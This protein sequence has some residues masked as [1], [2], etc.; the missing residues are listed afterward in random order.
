VRRTIQLLVL[1]MSA[2]FSALAASSTTSISMSP[3]PSDFGAPVTITATVTATATGTVTFYDGVRILGT[4]TVSGNQAALTTILLGT[5][6]RS[7]TARY[8]GDVNF[9]PSTSVPITQT[10]IAGA[11]IS[12]RSPISIAGGESSHQDVVMGD[13]NGD[14]KADAASISGSGLLINVWLGNGDGTFQTAPSVP[15]PTLNS[16]LIVADINN[17]G[18][19]DLVST[20]SSSNVVALFKGN[21]DGTFQPSVNFAVAG[22][23]GLAVT[24]INLDG[25]ADFL[26]AKQFGGLLAVMIGNGDGTFQ[27]AVDRVFAVSSLHPLVVGDFNGDSKPDLA[28][29]AYPTTQLMVALG[30]GDGSFAAPVGFNIASSPSSI[31]AG[32]VN[33]DGRL[34]LVLNA[35]PFISVLLGNGDGTFQPPSNTNFGT[36]FTLRLVIVDVTGDGKEDALL[37]SY[38]SPATLY[39]LRGNGDGTLQPASETPALDAAPHFAAGD[40]NGDAKV[41]VLAAANGYYPNTPG[42]TLFLGSS[43]IDMATSISPGSG[44]TQGQ[45]GSYS[46]TVA[47]VGELPTSGAVGLTASLPAGFTPTAAS[48]N[49]WV[50]AVATTTCTR[51][52]T[53]APGTA[54]PTITISVNVAP[55]LTG[56]VTA[57]AT[58]SGGGDVNSANN[59]GT[60]TSPVRLITTTVLTAAPNPSTVSQ[61]VALT[62]TVTVGAT[63]TVVFYDGLDI[64]GSAS[65]NGSSAVLNIAT[66]GSGQHSL[67]ARYLGSSTFGTSVSSKVG[68]AVNTVASN[69]FSPPLKSLFTG[70]FYAA[71][72]DLTG[73]GKLDLVLQPSSTSGS[74]QIAILTGNGDG[75]FLPPSFVDTAYEPNGVLIADWNNDGRQDLTLTHYPHGVFHML[76][77]G[78]GTFQSAFRISDYL[79]M[80]VADINA[81]GKLDLVGLSNGNGLFTVLGKGDGTFFPQTIQDIPSLFESLA[82]IGNLNGD[83]FPDIVVGENNSAGKLQ[84]LIGNGDG[85]Y[86]TGAFY[87]PVGNFRSLKISDINLDGKA[88]V[89]ILSDIAASVYL[90]NGNGTFQAAVVTTLSTN[91][92]QYAPLLA[93]FNGDGKPDLAYALSPCIALY[94]G[95]GTGTF[96]GPVPVHCVGWPMPLL[97]ADLNS[98]GRTDLMGWNSNVGQSGVFLGGQFSGLLIKKTHFGGFTIGQSGSTYQITVTS[99]YFAATAGTVTVTDTLPSGFTATAMSG[100]GWACTLATRTCTR[101]DALTTL[102]SYPPIILTVSV[103][104]NLSPSTVSNQASV[105]YNGATNAISDPTALVSASSVQLSIP[106]APM[107][108]GQAATLTATVGGGLTGHVVFF[109]G[110]K[111]IGSALLSAGQAILTTRLVSAGNRLL[112]ATYSGDATHAPSSTGRFPVT[113]KAAPS[114]GFAPPVQYS[115]G[116]YP[117]DLAIADLNSDGKHDLVI[118]RMQ[119]KLS[120]L[121]GAG[122]GTF[123]SMPEL[124]SSGFYSMRPLVADLNRDG[125]PDVI[126]VSQGNVFLDVFLGNGDGTFQPAKK[127]LLLIYLRTA[128]ITDMNSDGLVDVV[129]AGGDFNTYLLRG[130]GDGTFADP[131]TIFTG[132]PVGFNE[133]FPALAI[134]D[135]NSD[136]KLDISVFS[137]ASSL[138]SSFT[139]RAGDGR[140]GFQPLYGLASVT[141]TEAVDVGDLNGDFRPD[142]I[143]TGDFGSAALIQGDEPRFSVIPS[144]ARGSVLADLNGDGKLDMLGQ[145][146]IALGNGDGSFQPFFYFELNAYATGQGIAAGDFNGDGRTDVAFLDSNTNRLLVYLGSQ[147]SIKSSHLGTFA[148]GQIGATYTLTVWNAGP[149]AT[150]GTI[151]VTDTLPTGLTATALS[152][153]GWNC[154]VA[155]TTCTRSDSLPANSAYP[156]LTVTVNV[157]ANA[158]SPV[159]NQVTLSGGGALTVEHSDPTHIGLVQDVAISKTHVGNFYKGQTAAKYSIVV[160]NFG[161]ASTSSSVSVTEELPAGLTASQISGSGWT[162]TQPSGPCTRSDSLAIG[163]SYPALTLT[164]SV[165]LTAPSV[166]VNSAR[167]FSNN[168]LNGA[169]NV[170]NDTTIIVPATVSIG[171]YNAGAWKLDSNG[172]GVFDANSDRSF[173]LGFAGATQFTGDWNGDGRTKAGVYS[174]GY[175]YLDYDGNGVWDNGVIDKLIAWGWAGVTPFVGDWNGNGKTKIGVYSNGFW[176]LDYD[177]N[178]LWD[179]GVTDKQIGWGWAGVTPFVGDWNGNGKTK[180]GVYS[181]GFWFLDYDGN[182]SWDGGVIDKQVGWGWAGVTPIMGDW[183]GDGRMKIGV[184]SGGYWYIDYDGN[185]LWQYPATDKI[186]AMGWAGTTPVIGDWNGDG[187]TKAGAFINGFWYLDHNGNGTFDNATIDRIFGFGAVGDTPVV[188]RW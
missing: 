110:S 19:Q 109:D 133:D 132:T 101:S 66:L 105:T 171:T 112:S 76:G 186:L 74:K 151:T 135:F 183:N 158:P 70:L 111:P 147:L 67:S 44:F 75:T 11:S 150:F 50:C 87:N 77:N 164:V 30:N 134:E 54:F 88:D 31:A 69:G 68:L 137:W 125:M 73:D 24:D 95:T 43:L 115:P 160:S 14:N 5:G 25:K 103:A 59:T 142:I 117:T 124:D 144:Q 10:V 96:Q 188:G 89:Q 174:N 149:S 93:D 46:V 36:T 35:S 34:D 58:S 26:I 60:D 154:V 177:G 2:H 175:W 156:S 65:I 129:V 18:K 6:S 127:T 79:W 104:G 53:I 119:G 20:A 49:G 94:L 28:F 8:S 17:D 78:N 152:G 91:Q 85:T 163:G 102:K 113:V 166:I 141:N 22:P 181:N 108:F 7:L 3:N 155:T 165:S 12:L 97:A 56:N 55:G 99:P 114:A 122:D 33:H 71:S 159:A 62:A 178:Y 27:P 185:Y 16:L 63:G 157:A 100:A 39:V 123:L 82:A 140:G 145:G 121:L 153:T 187:R 128:E 167:V 13:F 61:P 98:D 184:Y 41:D 15:A 169:N 37:M 80:N 182:Y 48:G 4:K 38:A 40:W 143:G 173:F 72:G 81:D 179:G 86:Q 162:C 130:N 170:A 148:P 57:A 176:F 84:V 139:V 131:V 116:L 64:V 42:L 52:D 45:P 47:N 136:Q 9:T 180:I 126:G 106:P 51:S 90:G 1:A 161:Q 21:G 138:E 32:D 23:I 92:S 118:H 168:D 172:N 83:Q 107:T 29:G 120:V 146:A